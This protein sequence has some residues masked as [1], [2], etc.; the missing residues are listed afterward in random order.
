MLN[1]FW[2]YLA[3]TLTLINPCVLPLLPIIV[4][5]AFQ[6]SRKG[7]LLLALGLVVSFTIV[8][9]GVTAFGHLVGI[10]DAVINRTAAVLMVLFGVVLLVPRAQ[11]VLATMTSPLASGANS[12]LDKLQGGASGQFFVGVLLGAVWSPCIGP[13]LGGAIGLAAS[14]D[15]LVQATFTMVAFGF[16]VSTILLVLAYGSRELLSSR[17]ERLMALM[18]WA[19]PIMGVTLLVVGLA[20]FFHWDRKLET[21]LLDIMPIWLQDLSVR[22]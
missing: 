8:G 7:P 18:P 4:A 2:A 16:G 11:E 22:F 1:L 12:R 20:I 19:K 10:D 14:G 17:R 13:T 5:T 6:S 3:G 21:Y 15:G 9:V